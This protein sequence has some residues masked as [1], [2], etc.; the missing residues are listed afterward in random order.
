MP[1]ETP[2]V[3]A[4]GTLRYSA[5]PDRV[6]AAAAAGFGRIGLAIGDYQALRSAGWTDAQLHRVLNA[7]GVTIDEAEVLY[8][9]AGPSGPAGI[10]ERP[11]LVYADPRL[12]DTAWHLAQEFGVRHVQAVGRFAPG[13]PDTAVVDSFG[14]LCDRAAVHGATVALEFV[15]Y[16]DIPDLRS[17]RA[18]VESTGRPNG[19][20]CLDAWHFFRGPSSFEDLADLPLSLV[21]MV[22]INDGPGLPV[23]ANPMDDAVHHRR[24]PGEGDFDLVRLLSA[25]QGPDLRCSYSVEVYSDDLQRM[26]STQ[27]ASR[28]ALTACAVLRD[29]GVLPA[30]GY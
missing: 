16:T 9:F 20:I 13:L 18:V 26:P 8:G 25:L 23:D 1:S 7:H 5:F 4:W 14:R 12:E 6:A 17:A 29:S 27:A 11:G 24:C 2:L 22:Q 19:A 10:P 30:Q 21:A 3:L 28:A 15:P